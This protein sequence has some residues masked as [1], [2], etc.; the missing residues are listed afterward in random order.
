MSTDSD[1]QLMIDIQHK[2]IA[3]TVFATTR[4][5]AFY[6]VHGSQQSAIFRRGNNLMMQRD[7]TLLL[8]YK[9]CAL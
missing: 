5:G 9:R 3:I 8:H 7:Q 6:K 1:E 4:S 2:H